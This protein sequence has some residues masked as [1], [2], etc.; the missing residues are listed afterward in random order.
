MFFEALGEIGFAVA[1][2]ALR[3]ADFCFTIDGDGKDKRISAVE[4]RLAAQKSR[5]E[6][7]KR[8]QTKIRAKR[9]A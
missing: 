1:G 4:A 5:R 9:S 6:Q 7:I 8:R 3:F 2:G